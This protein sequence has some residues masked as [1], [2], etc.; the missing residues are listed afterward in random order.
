MRRR[1]ARASH[2]RQVAVLKSN[3]SSNLTSLQGRRR[4]SKSGTAI[5]CHKRSPSVEGTSRGEHERGVYPLS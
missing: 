4:V 1:L 3:V 5:E 2:A